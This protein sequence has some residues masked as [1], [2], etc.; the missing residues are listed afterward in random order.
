M[1]GIAPV[2]A[3][4]KTEGIFEELKDIQRRFEY[5]PAS[6]LKRVAERR[7]IGLRE[8]HAVASFYPHFYLKPPAKVMV[9][10]CDDM[11]C[12]LR[13]APALQ[14]KLEQR[15]QGMDEAELCIRN[16]SCVGR[17]DHAPALVINDRYYDGFSPEEAVEAVSQTMV[18]NPPEDSRY[19]VHE[20]QLMCDP[21]EGARPYSA[22]RELVR[23]RD[24]DGLLGK[25]KA[26]GL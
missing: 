2:T 9:R 11:T 26:A 12:H 25:I 5:L 1:P 7:G 14:R 4:N 13:G 22:L 10:V 24:T 21:Y 18:G 19:R 15:F 17:C 3:T 23:S 16:V 6:E 20:M 8:V